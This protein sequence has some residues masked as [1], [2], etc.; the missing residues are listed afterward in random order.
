MDEYA[1]EGIM[2]LD[3]PLTRDEIQMLIEA[4]EDVIADGH[5]ENASHLDLHERL[6]A[7]YDKAACADPSMTAAEFTN[8]VYNGEDFNRAED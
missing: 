2:R 5:V 4:L 8:A 3:V 6:L 1:G 7:F